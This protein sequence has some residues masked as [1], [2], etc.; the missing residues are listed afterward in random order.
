VATGD[1][2]GIAFRTDTEPFTDARVRKAIRIVSDRQA[3]VELVLGPDGGIVAC[4]HP[5]W[6]KDQYRAPFDCPPPA[7]QA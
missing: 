7:D 6:T 2:I 1:W 5:V 4:D 3:M